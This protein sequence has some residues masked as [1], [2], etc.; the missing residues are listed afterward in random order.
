M[1]KTLMLVFKKKRRQVGSFDIRVFYENDF[2]LSFHL[3]AVN[4]SWETFFFP[5]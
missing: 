2:D 4:I 1:F 5:G 3:C